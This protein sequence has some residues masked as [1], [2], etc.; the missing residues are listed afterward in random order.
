M[1][2]YNEDERRD[3]DLISQAELAVAM[4]VH[5]MTISRWTVAGLIPCHRVGRI[6]RYDFSVVLAAIEKA[7]KKQKGDK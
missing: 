1:N 2:A 7:P 3:S 6:V 5:P 4:S